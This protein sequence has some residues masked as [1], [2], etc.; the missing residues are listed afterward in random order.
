MAATIRRFERALS[1]DGVDSRN[2]A[3]NLRLLESSFSSHNFTFHQY[4]NVFQFIAG[5]VTELSRNSILSHDQVLHTVLEHDPRQCEAR[6][7]SLDAV[8]EM[9]LREVLVSALGMQTLDR[10]VS[11]AL[12]QM[13][14]LTGRLSNAALTRMMNYDPERLV[15]P[16]PRGQARHRR[17][18]DAGLQGPGTEA[19]G[20]LRPPG[21]AGLHPDHRAVQRHAG[22]GLP[23]ALRRHP[24]AHGH[25]HRPSAEGDRAAAGRSRTGCSRSP[26]GPER[27]SPCRGS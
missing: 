11:A 10:Y 2:L 24:G 25:R 23:A 5:S 17:P 13:S 19:D 18:D 27:P 14:T 1:A 22:D 8:A 12:R 3:A 21:P 16:Y 9:V 6:G 15:S 26:S 7:M 20:L 4:Q